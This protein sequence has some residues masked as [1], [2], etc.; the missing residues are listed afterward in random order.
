MALVSFKK[1]IQPLF[2]PRDVQCM[3]GTVDLNSYEDVKANA[4]EIYTR[5]TTTD[6]GSAMPPDGWPAGQIATFRA[7][8]DGGCQA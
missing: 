8:M 1:D 3:G 5:L 4:D 7:W 6:L 2:R